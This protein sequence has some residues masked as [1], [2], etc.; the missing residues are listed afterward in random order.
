MKLRRS[1]MHF[2]LL[3]CYTITLS[4]QQT[5]MSHTSDEFFGID[6]VWKIHLQLEPKEWAKMRLPEDM[7]WDFQKA[8]QELGSD[9]ESGQNFQND[10]SSR[11]GLAGY[12]GIH[13]QYGKGTVIIEQETLRNVG[14]RYKGNGTFIEGFRRNKFSFKI[15]FNEFVE[16][17]DF[18]GLTKINLHSNITDPSMMREVLSYEAFRE[19]GVH[20]SRTA[21]A[22]VFLTVS[23]QFEKKYL[24]IFSIVEQVDKRFL[25]HRF[26]TKKGLL[27]KPS[28]FGVFRY[29]GED[30]K[31]Y[32]KA[33][34]PKTE[35][36]PQQSKRLMEFARL[37]QKSNDSS[38]ELE[39]EN[40]LDIDQFLRFL[41][42][43][44][45]LSNLDSFLGSTQNYYVYLNPGPNQFQFIPWDLDH[46]FGAFSVV[47]TLET[48]QGLSI[49]HP[50]SDKNQLIERIL[51]IPRFKQS[52]H[53]Y[54]RQYTA[55]WFHKENMFLRIDDTA[56]MIRPLVASEGE[57]T[58]RR[59][60]ETLL[61]TLQEG[62]AHALKHFVVKRSESVR[63]QLTGESSGY[64]LKWGGWGEKPSHTMKQRIAIA[65]I[66]I[67]VLLNLFAYIRGIMAGFRV[68]PSWGCLNFFLYPIAPLYYGYKIRTDIGHGS[69]RMILWSLFILAMVLLGSIRILP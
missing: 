50:Q 51:A 32:E 13:H 26:G 67:A 48:R 57:N 56:E 15:D 14:I 8:F 2:T 63:S 16:D 29:F 10:Q 38:F 34:V 6:K 21:W 35:V 43:N 24:G 53:E 68:S 5:L 33:Y 3:L 55:A 49:D 65:S 20:C 18:R 23:G 66:I 7:D 36:T 27:L 46:S 47:G 19:A 62:N 64:R 41:A 11:P 4:R 28:T 59:F 40:Y 42:V 58:L 25:N 39:I 60:E 69:A 54:L 17:Q 52:Y 61:E 45:L 1:F 22:E 31:N 44:V 12:F 37:V 30:W 9:A